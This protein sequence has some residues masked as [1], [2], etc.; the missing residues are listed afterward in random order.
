MENKYKFCI[1]TSR[2]FIDIVH[3]IYI[4]ILKVQDAKTKPGK[5]REG[6]SFEGKFLM[7]FI[8]KYRLIEQTNQ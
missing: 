5:C 4:I 2:R 6:S 8:V 1:K 3:N 7:A